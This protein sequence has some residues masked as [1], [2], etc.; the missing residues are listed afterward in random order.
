VIVVGILGERGDAVLEIARRA[1]ATGARTEVVGAAPAGERGDR[2][3]LAVAKAGV[4]HATVTRAMASDAVPTADIEQVIEPGIEPAI[5][6]GIEPGVEPAIQPGI[7]PGIE[8][9]D[10][11][12][13]LRYLPDLRAIVLVAPPPALLATAASAASFAGATLIVVGRVDPATLDT[14][15]SPAPIVLDPPDHDP[16]AAFAGLVAAL[17]VRLDAGEEPSAAWAGT[18]AS[19][20]VEPADESTPRSA[21]PPAGPTT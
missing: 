11:E 8:P 12:L 1:A 4:G 15:G 21:S 17:A 14:L 18:M 19:L 3:L 20:V 13:A 5:Q 16:E 2:V 6:P 7:E 9:A 10:L